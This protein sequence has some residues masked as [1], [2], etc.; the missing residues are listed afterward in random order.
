MGQATIPHTH[1][2]KYAGGVADKVS[3][4][5]L[6]DFFE[7]VDNRSLIVLMIETHFI[8]HCSFRFQLFTLV[9]ALLSYFSLNNNTF[10]HLFILF[11]TQVLLRLYSPDLT[12][13]SIVLFISYT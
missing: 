5:V 7:S 8:V 3:W 11:V 12:Y 10:L 9:S 1:L 13:L 6:K 4:A 2:L